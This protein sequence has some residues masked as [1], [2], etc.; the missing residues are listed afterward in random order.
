[1]IQFNNLFCANDRSFYKHLI[2]TSQKISFFDGYVVAHRVNNRNSLIGSR[3]KNFECNIES[4]KIIMDI[5]KKTPDKF[6]DIIIK[7][8][9]DGIIYWAERSKKECGEQLIKEIQRQVNEYLLTLNIDGF[10]DELLSGFWYYHYKLAKGEIIATVI[11]QTEKKYKEVKSKLE[12]S[13]PEELIKSLEFISL[14][15]ASIIEKCRIAKGKY[16]YFYPKDAVINT[17]IFFVLPYNIVGHSADIAVV[18]AC[19]NKVSALIG[20]RELAAFS[21]DSLKNS[22][23]IISQTQLFLGDKI[24]RKDLLLDLLGGKNVEKL[25]VLYLLFSKNLLRFTRENFMNSPSLGNMTPPNS[26]ESVISDCQGNNMIIAPISENQKYKFWN[27]YIL[28]YLTSIVSAE[29]YKEARSYLQSKSF[30]SYGMP[31]T[32]GLYSV[33]I[34]RL[35][36]VYKKAKKLLRAFAVKIYKYTFKKK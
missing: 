23:E 33:P 31:L 20:K 11:F 21:T 15:D 32:V 12:L 9:L 13:L 28:W 5:T 29:T 36:K 22:K 26:L 27:T 10:S 14:E 25:K 8:E 1:G 19:N 35:W 4:C 6:R 18:N 17:D 24:F 3:F 16:I 2:I 34:W 30:L 7:N